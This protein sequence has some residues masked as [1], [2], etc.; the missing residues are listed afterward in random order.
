MKDRDLPEDDLAVPSIV[1]V[2][3]A[4]A[5][6]VGAVA[7]AGPAEGTQPGPWRGEERDDERKRP[8]G[9]MKQPIFGAGSPS[10]QLEFYFTHL[11]RKKVSFLVI[12]V[13]SLPR[14]F[15]LRKER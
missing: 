11:R 3:V 8:K 13:E 10:H 4:A 15:T 14:P 2:S 9:K 1:A 7:G 12:G 5:A 6:V